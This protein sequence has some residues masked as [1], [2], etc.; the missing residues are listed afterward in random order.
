MLQIRSKR[1]AKLSNPAPSST[2]DGAADSSANASS[3]SPTRSPLSAKK[4]SEPQ[5]GP[6]ST[7]QTPQ[8]SEGKRIKISPATSAP[9]K[10]RSPAPSSPGTPPPAKQES[11][12]SF[13]DRTLGAVFRLALKQGAQRDINGQRIF[14]PGLQSELQGEG[15]ELLIQ[16]SNLDQALLEAA[17]NVEQQRPLDY[18]LPCW[19]RITKLHKGFRRARD[20]DP[21]FQVLCEARRLCMSYCIFA[22]TMPEMFGYVEAESFQSPTYFLEYLLIISQAGLF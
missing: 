6:A 11:I 13:E 22:I 5:S 4:Q 9:E 3:P 20:D 8:L 10:P 7:T 19:K 1:L 14:L 12:E 18:L 15:K 17:S 21:K 16:T 2:T